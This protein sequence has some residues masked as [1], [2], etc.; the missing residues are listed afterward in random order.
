MSEPSTASSGTRA[1]ITKFVATHGAASMFFFVVDGPTPSLQMWSFA[2]LTPEQIDATI[3]EERTREVYTFFHD[4]EELAQEEI[5]IV[6][7]YPDWP[8]ELDAADERLVA[9]LRDALAN[10][11]VDVRAYFQ[12]IDS[13]ELLDVRANR[14]A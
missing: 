12:H 10:S 5:D 6:D 2:G 1:A 8:D 11:H 4:F 7:V 14:S 13:G 9:M 3:A